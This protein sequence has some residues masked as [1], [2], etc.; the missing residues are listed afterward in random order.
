MK[1]R[2]QLPEGVSFHP[3]G[4]EDDMRRVMNGMVGEVLDEAVLNSF[5]WLPQF[6][7]DYWLDK[8]WLTEVA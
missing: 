2:V 1:V 4:C 8:R 3:N 6:K 5:V 7:R